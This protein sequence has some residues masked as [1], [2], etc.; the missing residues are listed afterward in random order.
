MPRA[1]LPRYD[2]DREE[3][4]RIV[5]LLR[6]VLRVLP[7]SNREVER[8][9]GLNVGYLS[10]LFSGTIELKFEQIVAICRAAGLKPSE[11]F[12]LAYGKE[13]AESEAAKV[14]RSRVAAF[15]NL[16]APA[17]VPGLD[18]A[19]KPEVTRRPEVAREPTLEEQVHRAMATFFAHLAATF[20]L[21]T[22]GR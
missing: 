1:K 8:R 3:T 4:K 14:L 2:V 17:S 20:P 13:S 6:T 5:D 9:L 22:E 12:D 19:A 21:S 11:F 16:Q 10:R 18:S 7:V 15:K